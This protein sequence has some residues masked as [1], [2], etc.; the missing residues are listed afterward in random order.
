VRPFS[1]RDRQ[2]VT[3][4]ADQAVIAIENVRLFREIQ[5]KSRQLEIANQHKSEFLG[6]HVARAANAAE[7]HHRLSEVLLER[8]FGELNEKQ[9]RIPEGHL[10]IGQAPALA[11]QRHPGPVEDRSRPHGAGRREL[12]RAGS[13]GQRDDAGARA[14]PATCITLGLEVS[15]EVGEVRADERKFKQICQLAD[16]RCEVH[17]RR[18]QRSNVRA[19]LIDGVLEVAVRD[20][21]IASPRKTSARVRG[22][23]SGWAPHTTSRRAR[24]GLALTQRFVELHGGTI[25]L[26]SE[27]GKG[28]VFHVH[29]AGPVMSARGRSKALIAG[30][31]SA[32]GNPLSTI[33]IVED[34]DKT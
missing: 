9:E 2:L 8:M 24:P 22:V 10:L 30:A 21:G 4:F 14:G 7:R 6:Q 17:A 23:S 12:R 27:L 16:Q 25:R 20:T 29:V 31:R 33:L 11:D 34:N 26:E 13:A 18:W 15:A 32:E 5:D 3:T 1:E 28:S 19:R